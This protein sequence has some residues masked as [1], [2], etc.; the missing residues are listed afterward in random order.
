MWFCGQGGHRKG[1]SDKSTA[2]LVKDPSFLTVDW[3][4]AQ[5]GKRS[6]EA[7][8]EYI[9]F[10]QAG[11]KRACPWEELKARCILGSKEFLEKLRPGLKDKSKIKEIPGCSV[12]LS[13]PL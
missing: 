7:R 6:G 2:G 4:L 8:R 9:V 11:M 5:F 1:S 3:I 13:G 10:V 12:W